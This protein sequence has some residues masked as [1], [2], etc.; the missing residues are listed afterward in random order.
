MKKIRITYG[1]YFILLIATLNSLAQEMNTIDEKLR[2]VTDRSVYATGENICFSAVAVASD[3]GLSDLSKVFYVELV[4]PDGSRVTG[5]K[6]PLI[7]SSGDGCLTIP[8]ETLTGIYYLKCYTRVMRNGPLSGYHFTQLKIINPDN[9]RVLSILDHDDDQIYTTTILREKTG[10]SAI[11]LNLK[12]ESY[13]PR[14]EVSIEIYDN[15]GV[16]HL[17]LAVVPDGAYNQQSGLEIVQLSSRINGH[18]IAETRG[19][20]LS[21][22]LI[23]I[24][25]EKPLAGKIVNLSIIGDKDI[26][27]TRTDSS[28]RF[29]FALP[30]YTGSRDIF[31]CAQDIPGLTSIIYVDNDFCPRTFSLS[32][33]D[34]TMDEKEAALAYRLA[35][36][37]KIKTAFHLDTLSEQESLYVEETPFYGL[38]SQTLVLSDY[39][40][41]PTLTEYFNELPVSVRVRKRQG[42]S[43]F[44]F[45]S[46]QAEMNIFDPLVMIDWVAVQNMEK[47]LAMD[48]REVDHIEFINAPYVK[49]DITYGGV[50]SFVSKNHDFAG[51]DLPSSGT[52]IQYSL[53]D[54]TQAPIQQYPLP[55]NYPDARNTIYW[56][57]ELELDEKGSAKISFAAPDTPGRYVIVLTEMVTGLEV[58]KVFSVSK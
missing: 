10:K 48:P 44:R 9:P 4:T 43:H 42:L 3:D 32:A 26:M 39:I 29:F 51:I 18:Y 46:T 12:K 30:D 58:R 34:F 15:E 6:Y 22:S 14:E 7:H 36:N 41:L 35:V 38:P 33:P 25:S 5:G 37:H 47:I 20:S 16:E 52:F 27:V 40:D 8:G 19:V 17:S 54:G 57:P 24:Q 31:L 56:E 53:Y 21:G 28:G 50:V 45:S 1:F 49:G 23:D 2:I 55:I 13:L 11:N